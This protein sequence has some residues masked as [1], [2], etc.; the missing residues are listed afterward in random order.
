MAPCARRRPRT[1]I[2][3]KF[4]ARATSL[5]VRAAMYPPK[6]VDE[7]RRLEVLKTY[8][9]LDTQ[10]EPA[11]DDIARLAAYLFKTPIALITLVDERREWFKARVGLALTEATREGLCSFTVLGP[12][13]VVTTDASSDPRFS[14]NPY[15]TGPPNVRFYA[16]A[17]LASPEGPIIGT[18][19]VLDVVPR[20]FSRED[21]EAL[22]QL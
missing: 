11:F 21:G 17:P 1:A 12:E 4:G 18:L 22:V 19:C 8:E 13:L 7:A 5:W 10:A 9:I 3:L 15:V 16:G 20:E 2:P 14:C 6:P